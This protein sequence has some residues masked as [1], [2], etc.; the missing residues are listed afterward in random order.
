MDALKTWN[1]FQKKGKPI[2]LLLLLLLLLTANR[3]DA[4]LKALPKRK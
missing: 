3:L 1:Y 2:Y 4:E